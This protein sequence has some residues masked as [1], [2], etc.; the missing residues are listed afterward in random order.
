MVNLF[1]FVMI[2]SICFHDLEGRGRRQM[3]KVFIYVLFFVKDTDTN[4][5]SECSTRRARD[6]VKNFS[7]VDDPLW[8]ETGK[9]FTHSKN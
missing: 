2:L 5:N 1:T 8:Q 6:V 4:P 7:S 3:I 9:M